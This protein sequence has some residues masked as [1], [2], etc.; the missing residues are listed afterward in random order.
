MGYLA[1]FVVRG[2]VAQSQ[3]EIKLPL[4]PSDLDHALRDRRP[5]GCEHI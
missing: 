5:K 2:F 1:L 4:T 3:F